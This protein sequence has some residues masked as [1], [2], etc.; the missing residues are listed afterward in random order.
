MEIIYILFRYY[1]FFINFFGI[2]YICSFLLYVQFISVAQINLK[3]FIGFEMI[4][5]CRYH[6]FMFSLPVL[7]VALLTFKVSIPYTKYVRPIFWSFINIYFCLIN[8]QYNIQKFI[9]ISVTQ[10]VNHYKALS[11]VFSFTKR[12]FQR[13]L[14]LFSF[15]SQKISVYDL[16]LSHHWI[17]SSKSWICVSINAIYYKWFI[18]SFR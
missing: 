6:Y 7:A 12:Y 17:V 10:I 11:S 18:F 14:T 15:R 8:F 16:W 3:S 5:K 13:M 2:L 4:C 9:I 1:I